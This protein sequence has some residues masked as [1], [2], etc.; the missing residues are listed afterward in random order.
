VFG[1]RGANAGR[2][3]PAWPQ[4]EIR[5]VDF[6]FR[7]IRDDFLNRHRRLADP[8]HSAAKDTMREGINGEARGLTLGDLT[9]IR[10]VDGDHDAHLSEIGRQREQDGR[11][12]GGGDGL[13]RISRGEISTP[14]ALPNRL[15]TD[16]MPYR[17]LTRD[18]LG[19][20]FRSNVRNRRPVS[21]FLESQATPDPSRLPGLCRRTW[22]VLEL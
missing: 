3:R 8:G 17:V 5:I 20:S 11:L 9:D 18:H 1:T 15:T 19:V 12:K 21:L 2:C 22:K 10:L 14:G 13:S 6:D 4:G 7:S 16:G